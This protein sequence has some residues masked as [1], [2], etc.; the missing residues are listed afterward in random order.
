MVDVFM[1]AALSMLHVRL[2]RSGR[3]NEMY[4][5]VATLEA[6]VDR[7]NVI[8]FRC[9]V[10]VDMLHNAECSSCTTLSHISRP[11]RIVADMVLGPKFKPEIFSLSSS[12]SDLW[13]PVMLSL[14][15]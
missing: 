11:I 5:G 14:E 13:Q 8:G 7:A 3:A 10:N 15:S 12:T 1:G 6:E 2:S 4:V 9:P